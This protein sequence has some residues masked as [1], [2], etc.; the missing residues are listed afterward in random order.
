MSAAR[1][2]VT[3]RPLS[4]DGLTADV[5]ASHDGPIGAVASFLGLVRAENLGP[6]GHVPG[7]RGVR[8]AGRASRSRASP[9]RSASVWPGATIGVHHRVGRVDIGEASIAIVAVSAA[10]RGCVCGVPVRHRAGEADRADLEARA[11]RG[12]RR[13]DRRRHGR[14]QTMR[15][16][17]W[18]RGDARARDGAAVCA[19]EGHRRRGGARSRRP[20][21]GDAGRRVGAAGTRLPRMAPYRGS[22]S[23]ALNAEYARMDASVRDGD[24]VAFLPPVSGG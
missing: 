12:R 18:K 4:L 1:F 21:R 3:E 6:R 7:L 19:A 16:R 23:G 17:G 22:V 10:S 14:R 15:R 2:V 5:R 11:L 20:R 9:T 13:L 8:A 24:E